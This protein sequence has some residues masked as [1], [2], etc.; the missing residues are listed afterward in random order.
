MQQAARKRGV[1]VLDTLGKSSS[2]NGVIPAFGE[3]GER[4]EKANCDCCARYLF[5]PNVQSA[6]HSSNG[7]MCAQ[8]VERQYLLLLG[9]GSLQVANTWHISLKLGEQKALLTVPLCAMECA[10][11]HNNGSGSTPKVRPLRTGWLP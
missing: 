10:A 1:G 3:T 11:D 5:V 4:K 8:W 7:R 2:C 6:A 9:I